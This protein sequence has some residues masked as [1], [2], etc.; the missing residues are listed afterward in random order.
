MQFSFEPTR[1]ITLEDP[2]PIETSIFARSNNI[3]IHMNR[4]NFVFM[5]L[6]KLIS[7]VFLR[8]S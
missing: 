1:L 8:L 3:N 6:I 2:F 4:D 5:T 7:R